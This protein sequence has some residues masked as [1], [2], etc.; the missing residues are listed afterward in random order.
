MV[1]LSGAKH[2]IAAHLWLDFNLDGAVGAANTNA[3][4]YMGPNA[5]ALPSIDPAVS[6]DVRLNPPATV[7]EK[8]VELL[9]L[10]PADL[11]KYTSRWN[12]LRA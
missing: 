1:I 7:Q 12:E 9:Y 4:G 10:P 2:P 5:A 3:I 8:L 11:D 6:G